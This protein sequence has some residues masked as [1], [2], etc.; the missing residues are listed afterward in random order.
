[1]TTIKIFKRGWWPHWQ[2]PFKGKDKCNTIATI[3][4]TNR[5]TA[6]N[7]AREMCRDKNQRLTARERDADVKYEWTFIDKGDW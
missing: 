6:M 3:E 5:M 2:F 1:M 4:H 7:R